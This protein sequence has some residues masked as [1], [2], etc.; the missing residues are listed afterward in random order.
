MTN[1][2][3]WK[4]DLRCESQEPDVVELYEAL[5][6]F[7]IGVCQHV[8]RFA[9]PNPALLAP[10]RIFLAQHGVKRSARVLSRQNSDPH[11]TG[12]TAARI[13]RAFVGEVVDYANAA[14]ERPEPLDE[15]HR[16]AGGERWVVVDRDEPTDCRKAAQTVEARQRLIPA[17]LDVLSD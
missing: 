7:G 16:L 17:N 4:H 10:G 11:G 3:L 2:F 15:R 1:N 9:R 8:C 12:S 14:G 5:A 6:A 13:F